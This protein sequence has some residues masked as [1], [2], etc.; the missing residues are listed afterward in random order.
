LAIGGL[1]PIWTA[2]NATPKVRRTS[3]GKA[4]MSRRLDAIQ[5]KLLGCP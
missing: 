1:S 4:R 5:L 3:F 2:Y